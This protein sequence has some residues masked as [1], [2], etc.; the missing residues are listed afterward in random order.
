M[1]RHVPPLILL[2]IPALLGYLASE[3]ALRDATLKRQKAYAVLDAMRAGDVGAVH[4]A[5]VACKGAARCPM[6]F[7]AKTLEAL[8]DVLCK[9]TPVMTRPVDDPTDACDVE[10]WTAGSSFIRELC[11]MQLRVNGS[12]VKHVLALT[13]TPTGNSV[14]KCIRDAIGPAAVV[15]RAPLLC[16]CGFST[17]P[18]TTAAGGGAG[19]GVRMVEYPFE[20]ELGEVKYVLSALCTATAVL[21]ETTWDP[22]DVTGHDA[23]VL[24]Y[25]RITP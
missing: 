23:T 10:A 6:T 2:H 4:A 25:R 24:V 18:P 15:A 21:T 13:L 5:V 16:V 12:G 8:H 9:N 20:M 22:A 7:A 19:G 17:A 11:G 3:H 14:V 1:T